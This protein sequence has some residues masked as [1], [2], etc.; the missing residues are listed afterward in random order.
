MGKLSNRWLSIVIAVAVVGG[1]GLY[2]S[3]A[4]P[5]PRANTAS[6]P[7][8]SATPGSDTRSVKAVPGMS[9]GDMPGLFVKV[10]IVAGLLGGSLWLLRRYAGPGMRQSGRT[11]IV[12]IADTIPLAQGRSLYVVDIGDRA[13][14]VGATQQQFSLLAEMSDAETLEKLRARPERPAAPWTELSA[15][16]NAAIGNRG[17]GL[18]DRPSASVQP[19]SRSFAEAYS[20]FVPEHTTPPAAEQQMTELTDANARL[21]ELATRIR[22]A[23]RSA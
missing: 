17:Q 1:L 7:N 15:R 11:G 18:G 8:L 22:A 16:L 2:A 19:T 10:G 3:T 5:S 4:K 9:A 23:R 20:A 13:L 6:V 21:R 14:V 12:T